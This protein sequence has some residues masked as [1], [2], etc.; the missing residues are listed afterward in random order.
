MR[1]A[2]VV[3]HRHHRERGWGL[4]E[5]LM[6]LVVVAGL[7]VMVMHN[8]QGANVSRQVNQAINELGQIQ[9]IVRNVYG[10]QPSYAGLSVDDVIQANTLPRRMVA[11]DPPGGQINHVFGEQILITPNGST[12]DVEYENVP[13]EACRRLGVMDLGTGL[14]A[15]SIGGDNYDETDFPLTPADVA[16]SCGNGAGVSMIW[17]LR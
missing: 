12:F 6:G 5:I 17:T 4:L 9:A 11:N 15:I 14:S 13:A 3:H 10:M 16:G 8:Y 2:S 7:A 1:M